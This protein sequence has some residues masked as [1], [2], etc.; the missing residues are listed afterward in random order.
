ML[1]FYIA[2]ELHLQQNYVTHKFLVC[3]AASF[4]VTCFSFTE[5]N[6]YSMLVVECYLP[7]QKAQSF[8][9]PKIAWT[10]KF[11]CLA[12]LSR[13][14]QAAAM[15]EILTKAKLGRKRIC[16]G[17]K[18]GDHVYV[19]SRLEEEYPKLVDRYLSA[20]LSAKRRKRCQGFN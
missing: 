20:I 17:N 19:Q 16:F 15:L 3:E 5:S 11:C 12:E 10:A 6:F 1:V 2:L 18:K 9:R 4:V 8:W 7:S 14:T 13:K